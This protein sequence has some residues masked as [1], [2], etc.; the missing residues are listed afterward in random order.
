[1]ALAATVSET[2]RQCGHFTPVFSTRLFTPEYLALVDRKTFRDHG[3]RYTDELL[4][5]ISADQVRI[6]KFYFDSDP[7]TLFPASVGEPPLTLR[8]LKTKYPDH[9]VLLFTDGSGLF[10]SVSGELQVAIESLWAWPNIGLFTPKPPET[11][12]YKEDALAARAFIQPASLNSLLLFA[13]HLNGNRIRGLES[14]FTASAFPPELEARPNRWLE[15]DSPEPILVRQ[16]LQS[17]RWYLGDEGFFW[18]GACAVYPEI[19]YNLTIYLGTNLKDPTGK[20][21]FSAERLR[22]LSRLPW[23]RQ[24]YMP[25]WLRLELVMGLS[26]QQ[27]SQIREALDRLWLAAVSG[28][29]SAIRIEIAR[30]HRRAMTILARTIFSRLR[31][32]SARDAP[33]RDYVFASVML[34]RSLEPL[35]VRVPRIW[36]HLL[37]R[38]KESAADQALLPRLQNWT[39]R[40]VGMIFIGLPL[41]SL[42]ILLLPNRI[43]S[44]GAP[45]LF[46]VLTITA[47]ANV[48]G[49]LGL[50]LLSFPA[51]LVWLNRRLLL[52]GSAM[53][54]SVILGVFL[55]IALDSILVRLSQVAYARPPTTKT[56]PDEVSRIKERS[57]EEPQVVARQRRLLACCSAMSLLTATGIWLFGSQR[58]MQR[59]VEAW[60]SGT[61]RSLVYAGAVTHLL[62]PCATFFTLDSSRWSEWIC[63]PYLVFAVA[64]GCTTCIWGLRIGSR[65][66]LGFAFT[67]EMLFLIFF[68]GIFLPE[69]AKLPASFGWAISMLAMLFFLRRSLRDKPLARLRIFGTRRPSEAVPKSA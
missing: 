69:W 56:S 8:D 42:A 55:A 22:S 41:V 51:G 11:W 60:K 9:R 26:P 23:F 43:S 67:T 33:L 27:N 53:I 52:L 65:A 39:L 62:L 66:L 21:L 13:R 17:L 3:S 48:Y 5:G 68:I 59:R 31:S 45:S 58:P 50:S 16:V 14:S 18:L 46:S 1:L 44:S 6:Q 36:R 57:I 38:Q 47:V 32:Q 54:A 4:K 49:V 2:V 35:A 10:D 20:M 40:I 7:R 19:Q 25:N 24:A 63:I 29:T 61:V 12:G 15:R 37:K 30:L 64:L 28:S 34:G